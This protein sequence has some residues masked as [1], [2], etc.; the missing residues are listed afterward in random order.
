MSGSVAREYISRTL[1]QEIISAQQLEPA[2]FKV[3]FHCEQL[4]AED[5]EIKR[6]F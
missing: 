2:C 4:N 1:M 3:L 6:H 5:S